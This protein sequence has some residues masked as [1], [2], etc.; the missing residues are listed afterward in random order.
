LDLLLKEELSYSQA[1][2][3]IAKADNNLLI[4][5]ELKENKHYYVELIKELENA[6]K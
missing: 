6:K 2:Y 1:F 5:N 4:I 3:R